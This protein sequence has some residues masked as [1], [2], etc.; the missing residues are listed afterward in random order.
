[1]SAALDKKLLQ[2]SKFIQK[3][4]FD[5]AVKEYEKLLS[6]YKKD[7]KIL[8]SLG[9]TYI[10]MNMVEKAMDIFNDVA[11]KYIKDGFMPNAIAI[12]RKM[13]QTE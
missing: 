12:Y 2:V 13:L 7:P 1:M 11:E 8:N 4:Q 10:K 5:R 3:G 6:Q 9:D